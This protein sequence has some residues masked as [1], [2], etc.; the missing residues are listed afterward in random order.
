MAEGLNER[1]ALFVEHYIA[2]DNGTQSAISAGYAE[3][4]AHVTASRL[5]RIDKV[6]SAVTAARETAQQALRQ[7]LTVT[8]EQVVRG[9]LKLAVNQDDKT[10]HTVQRQAWKDLGTHLGMFVQRFA[11][12]DDEIDRAAAA[13]AEEFGLEGQ[14]QAIA[15]MADDILRDARQKRRR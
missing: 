13:A 15:D 7:A 6:A 11:V 14:E 8:E 5:L 2:T 1:Q 10:P 9:L 4:S 12:T 3:G